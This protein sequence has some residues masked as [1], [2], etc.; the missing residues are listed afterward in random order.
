MHRERLRAWHARRAHPI[1]TGDGGIDPI[2]LYEQAEVR[3]SGRQVTQILEA[4]LPLL[5]LRE[6][7]EGI[8]SEQSIGSIGREVPRCEPPVCLG[9]RDA[10]AE[11]RIRMYDGGFRWSGRRGRTR[12][13]RGY[14]RYRGR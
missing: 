5:L 13:D 10:V 7:R 1:G 6:Q 11:E 3:I 12:R 14:R 4:V 9:Q 8:G 2:R